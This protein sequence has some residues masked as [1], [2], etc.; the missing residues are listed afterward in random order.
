MQRIDEAI[1]TEFW[2][3]IAM[4]SYL[5]EAN[6]TINAIPYGTQD[7]RPKHILN[8]NLA[9]SLSSITAFSVVQS[10]FRRCVKFQMIA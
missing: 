5:T 3:L 9:K 4:R 2:W 8:S 6:T 1:Y 7:I 10:F